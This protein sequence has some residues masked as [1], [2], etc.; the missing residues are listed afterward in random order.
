MKKQVKSTDVLDERLAMRG[1]IGEM[2]DALA[3]ATDALA[4]NDNNSVILWLNDLCTISKD[5]IDR[6]T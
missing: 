1:R 4:R 2:Q 5:V 3:K 6:L